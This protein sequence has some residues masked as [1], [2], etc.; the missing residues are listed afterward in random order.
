MKNTAPFF[1]AAEKA[2][3]QLLFR[4]R[5]LGDYLPLLGR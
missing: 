1:K 5:D 3:L 4:V 2:G